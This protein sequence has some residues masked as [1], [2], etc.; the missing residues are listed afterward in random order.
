M[1]NDRKNNLQI[2]WTRIYLDNKKPTKKKRK[3]LK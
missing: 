1:N 2:L 3:T